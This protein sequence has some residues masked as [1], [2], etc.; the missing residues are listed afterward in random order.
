MNKPISNKELKLLAS[1][2]LKKYRE[3][4]GLYVIEGEHLIT[5]FIKSG[6]KGLLYVIM[7]HDYDNKLLIEKLTEH[8]VYRISNRNFELISETVSPQ[9]ILA[10]LQ[11]SKDNK[12]LDGNIIVALDSINDPGNLGTILRTCYWFGIDSVLIGKNSADIYNS[13]TIRASQGAI[14]YLN[15]KYDS[16]INIELE[17]F[18][19][20]GYNIYL[21]S[22][23]GKSISEKT[24]LKGKS[25]IVF[26]NEAN[27]ISKEILNNKNYYQI[28]ITSYTDCESLNVS[29]SAGI[30]INEFKRLLDIQ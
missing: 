16:D 27:G 6:N 15:L 2:K 18:L 3:L 26:G 23:S 5:E 4:H 21:A 24:V 12:S 9:G 25:I 8:T 1:L 10:V 11:I 17:K 28:K 14:F 13:K 29:V 7:R 30:V 22:L 20:K 19:D